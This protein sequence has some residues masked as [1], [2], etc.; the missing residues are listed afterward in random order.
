MAKDLDPVDRMYLAPSVIHVEHPW[1]VHRDMVAELGFGSELLNITGD[2]IGG[3]LGGRGALGGALVIPLVVY[4]YALFKGAAHYRPALWLAVVEQAA[5]ALFD[6]YHLARSDLRFG[7]A[8][9]PLVVSLTL[10]LSVPV[11]S[12]KPKLSVPKVKPK[13]MP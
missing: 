1:A 4:S 3:L 2:K 12:P 9:F 8:L 10:R 5:T 11:V 13:P 6:V 7:A